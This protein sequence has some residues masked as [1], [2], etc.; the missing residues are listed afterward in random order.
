MRALDCSILS[1]ALM[2]R[3]YRHGPMA[4]VCYTHTTVWYIQLMFA[5]I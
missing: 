3:C 5:V 4:L 1:T 2:M